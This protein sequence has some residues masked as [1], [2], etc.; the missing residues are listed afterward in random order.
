MQTRQG[1]ALRDATTAKLCA[2]LR[3]SLLQE[4]NR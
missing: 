2:T 4:T 3:H 1:L